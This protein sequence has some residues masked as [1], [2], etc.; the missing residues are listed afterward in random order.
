MYVEAMLSSDPEDV[1]LSTTT[2]GPTG[3]YICVELKEHTLIDHLTC[4]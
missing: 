1:C 4:I 2:V 3:G